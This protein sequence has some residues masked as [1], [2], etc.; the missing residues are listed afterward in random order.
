MEQSPKDRGVFLIQAYINEQYKITGDEGEF[1]GIVTAFSAEELQ[2]MP[3]LSYPVEL[4]EAIGNI[5]DKDASVVLYDL[6][7]MK[8]PDKVVQVESREDLAEAVKN[9]IAYI[10]IPASIREAEKG[11]VNSVMSEKDTLGVELGSA[12]TANI[13]AEIIYRFQM[14]FNKE[15]KEF[16]DL[17]SKLRCY[18]VRPQD[19]SG[20][21]IYEKVE[22][23]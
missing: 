14:M 2:N 21:L 6:L 3:I 19:A 8:N 9:R 5:V 4:L 18:H 12:G 13:L 11:L 7:V 10:F 16:K 17:K 1:A 23:Y 15:S 20:Y 22:A